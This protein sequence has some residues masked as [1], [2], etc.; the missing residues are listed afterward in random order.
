[1]KPHIKTYGRQACER[2]T[3]AAFESEIC[4]E[5]SVRQCVSITMS[6]GPTLMGCFCSEETERVGTGNKQGRESDACL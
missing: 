2:K 3:G 1:M 6:D 4:Q 5:A